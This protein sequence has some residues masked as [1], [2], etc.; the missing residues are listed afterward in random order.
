MTTTPNQKDDGGC[1]FPWGEHGTRLGGM[2]LRDYLA[3]KA[4]QAYVSSGA[5]RERFSQADTARAAYDMADTMLRA[6][7]ESI[8]G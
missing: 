5:W 3:A 1:A 7:Q 4:M 8:H 6:R 2:S